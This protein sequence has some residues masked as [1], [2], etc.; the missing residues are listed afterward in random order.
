M[1]TNLDIWV[2]HNLSL[3]CFVLIVILIPYPTHQKQSTLG[4]HTLCTQRTANEPQTMS[5]MVTA[6]KSRKVA[7]TKSRKAAA[8]KSS[9]TNLHTKIA[10]AATMP[11]LAA[12]TKPH[13]CCLFV[14]IHC[15]KPFIFIREVFFTYDTMAERPIGSFGSLKFCRPRPPPL[16]ISYLWLPLIS[17]FAFLSM[18]RLYVLFRPDH[19]I[20][21]FGF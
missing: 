19:L 17:D 21:W 14:A 2:T 18:H 6:T 11:Q 9:K 10:Q 1:P 7:A 4:L 8:T 20:I 3:H 15:E 13:H 12:A 5:R 16:P